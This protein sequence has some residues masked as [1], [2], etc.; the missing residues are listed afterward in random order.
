MKNKLFPLIIAILLINIAAGFAQ[1]PTTPMV[2][3]YAPM[4]NEW[5][6]HYS[7]WNYYN[8]NRWEAATDLPDADANIFIIYDYIGTTFDINV[9]VTVNSIYVSAKE[10]NINISKSITTKYF[11]VGDYSGTITANTSDTSTPI[12]AAEEILLEGTCTVNFANTYTLNVNS[13]T[14]GATVTSTITGR[15]VITE[16]LVVNGSLFIIG[17]EASCRVDLSGNVEVTGTFTLKTLSGSTVV[18]DNFTVNGGTITFNLDNDQPQLGNYVHSGGGT[19]AIT[20]LSGVTFTGFHLVEGSVTIKNDVQDPTYTVSGDFVVSGGTVNFLTNWVATLTFGGN[21]SIESGGTC[22]LSKSTGTISVDFQKDILITEG[23][24]SISSP[25]DIGDNSYVYAKGNISMAGGTFGIAGVDCE[26]NF[27]GGNLSLDAGN[28]NGSNLSIEVKNSTITNS[29]HVS[30]GCEFSLEASEVT[31]NGAITNGGTFLCTHADGS[32]QAGIFYTGTMINNSGDFTFQNKSDATAPT[33]IRI[34]AGSFVNEGGTFNFIGNASDSCSVFLEGSGAV[35]INGGELNVEGLDSVSIVSSYNISI[36]SNGKCSI[37]CL[38]EGVVSMN[39]SQSIA[40]SG[41][42]SIITDS[43]AATYSVINLN[44][45]E[46]L[47]VT[48]GGSLALNGSSVTISTKS[49]STAD[50]SVEITNGYI[51]SGNDTNKINVQVSSSVNCAGG[52]VTI[53]GN[54]ESTITFKPLEDSSTL[55]AIISGCNFSIISGK[56]IDFCND[57]TSLSVSD[58]AS[59]NIDGTTAQYINI[60]S[61]ILT[62]VSSSVTITGSDTTDIDVSSSAGF[63]ISSNSFGITGGKTVELSMSSVTIEENGELIINSPD[64]NPIS[65]HTT[66]LDGILLA[67]GGKIS[68]T[69]GDAAEISIDTNKFAC[70]AAGACTVTNGSVITF[71]AGTSFSNQGT[72]SLSSVNASNIN[73]SSGTGSFSNQGPMDI[74]GGGNT[75]ILVEG[76]DFSG[77]SGGEFRITDGKIVDVNLTGTITHGDLFA[78]NSTGADSI[79]VAGSSIGSTAGGEF[80]LT[81]GDATAIDLTISGGGGIKAGTFLISGGSTVAVNLEDSNGYITTANGSFAINSPRATT[82]DLETQKG[83]QYGN[84]FEITAGD[85]TAVSILASSADCEGIISLDDSSVFSIEGG[86]SVG[87]S[88]ANGEITAGDSFV[89]NS[90]QATAINLEAQ[91]GIKYNNQFSIT[92]G[93]ATAVA[94]SASSADCEGIISM[95]DGSQF[96]INGGSSVEINL[97]NGEIITGDSFSVNSPQATTINLEAQKGIKYNNQFT[98]TA[99]DATVVA[100][101]ASSADCEGIIS[102]DDNSVFSIEGGDVVEISIGVGGVISSGNSFSVNSPQ[103]SKIELETENGIRYK[104]R[105]EVIAGDNTDIYVAAIATASSDCEGII[106]QG[107]NSEFSITGGS[108]LEVF[109]GKG[110]LIATG[111]SFVIDSPQAATIDLQAHNGIEYKNRFEITA[112]NTTAISIL[113]SSADGE[114]IISMDDGS[115]FSINGGSSVEINLTNG[116]ISTGDS[117]VINSPQATAINLEAQKGIKYNNQ[118]TITAGD[119]TAVSVLASSADGEGIISPD[120]GSQFSINGGSSVEINL[121]NGEISTG[122]SFV[123]DSPQATAINLE[124]QK[125]IKYNNQFTITAGNTTAVSILASSSDGEGIISLDDSGEFSINGGSSVEITLADGSGIT[126]NNN[127][128]I[129]SPQATTINLTIPV[130]VTND[131]IFNLQ[132]GTGTTMVADFGEGIFLENTGS[133]F[134]CENGDSVTISALEIINASRINFSYAKILTMDAGLENRAGAVFSITDTATSTDY[135]LH[136]SNVTNLGEIQIVNETADSTKKHSLVVEKFVNGVTNNIEDDPAT[137]NGPSLKTVEIWDFENHGA[138]VNLQKGASITLGKVKNYGNLLLNNG[139]NVVFNDPIDNTEYLINGKNLDDIDRQRELFVIDL[140]ESGNVDFSSGCLNN[141][142]ILLNGYTGALSFGAEVMHCGV[143]VFNGNE[144]LANFHGSRDIY[145]DSIVEYHDVIGQTNLPFGD[146]YGSG[147]VAFLDKA[148]GETMQNIT[149][150]CILISNP[151]ATE[152]LSLRG[153]NVFTSNNSAPQTL[154]LGESG[155]RWIRVN[156]A[157]DYTVDQLL[158]VS[159]G[160]EGILLEGTSAGSPNHNVSAVN[161]RTENLMLSGDAMNYKF[162]IESTGELTNLA[163]D[164]GTVQIFNKTGKLLNIKTINAT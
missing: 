10:K 154:V 86:S 36:G 24:L 72:F 99:G 95:D 21:V 94:I 17:T 48:D 111:S 116:E 157:S 4:G 28:S 8:G 6:T 125:G 30:E 76:A 81:G 61:T 123:I 75:E 153:E 103:A 27:S 90:P 22:S 118:F 45:T 39:T 132:P 89:I 143:F 120:D 40:I 66:A 34:T 100:I 7:A 55:N 26:L 91:K 74:V 73:L 65:I 71:D 9:D 64:A 11:T 133:E 47:S 37:T 69:G 134:N 93:D 126:N 164:C 101:S 53:T 161:I 51:A 5:G 141:G 152:N 16:N 54:E 13:F 12:F 82:I 68:V 149:A 117:F 57:K 122:D 83:I 88:L 92:A 135:D 49:L 144:A 130:G 146:N 109:V 56:T 162:T 140:R 50:A 52:S 107:D 160:F 138:N 33:D 70:G 151:N 115:Q 127:F 2:G 105:F 41:V 142:L 131:G 163:A 129:S 155:S 108:F 145:T 18:I 1:A 46:G 38:D 110:G 58:G 67:T 150:G 137:F 59:V 119:A 44:A 104:G 102:L 15:A 87:I 106:S 147:T 42:C 98:I 156:A 159:G 29:L 80:S 158:D 62:T 139:E 84:P 60:K 14:V 136:F 148:S 23:N 97:T 121:T 78:I 3:D 124:A 63:S 19:T 43:N 85:A 112:G 77:G 79:N 35:Q 113:A 31:L 114:G 128:T 96:S 20:V 25:T 32:N